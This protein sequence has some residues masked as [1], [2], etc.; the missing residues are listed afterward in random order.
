MMTMKEFKEIIADY[1]DDLFVTAHES[2]KFNSPFEVKGVELVYAQRF[3]SI[4][5]K[6]IKFPS[7]C[8]NIQDINYELLQKRIEEEKQ[9]CP[10]KYS[11][12]ELEHHE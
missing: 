7:V 1:P 9:K 8:I 3:D 10:W 12:Q 4:T 6:W 5:N 2:D 11:K